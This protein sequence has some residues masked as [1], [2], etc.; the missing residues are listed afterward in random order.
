MMRL[1]FPHSCPPPCALPLFQDAV[2]GG[3]PSPAQDYIERQIDLNELLV[4]H[5]T[6]TY[7]VRV[8]GDSMRDANIG[9]GDVLIVDSSLR[10]KHDDIVIAAIN[11]EF[12]VKRLI[13]APHVQ[14]APMNPRYQ[15]IT[16][17]GEEEL[18]IFGVVTFIIY[19]AHVHR[20]TQ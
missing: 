3:F 11:G 4:A 18:Q 15:P 17:R 7:F 8:T 5:P 6:A 12:T 20:K 13:T 10:A 9:E 14:L 16:L 1:F 19:A 2:R